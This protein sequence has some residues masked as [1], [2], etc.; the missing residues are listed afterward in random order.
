MRVS[1][2]VKMDAFRSIGDFCDSDEEYASLFF[3][4]KSSNDDY[5]NGHCDGGDDF[6]Y[7]HFFGHS[8][9]T[10]LNSG[11][12]VSNESEV[13]NNVGCHDLQVYCPQ[14]EDISDDDSGHPT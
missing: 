7:D 1:L 9:A 8:N 4:Q 2:L 6:D 13:S 5:V 12:E 3:S 11:E 14:V 10:D